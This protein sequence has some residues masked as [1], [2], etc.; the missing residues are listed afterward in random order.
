MT[1]KIQNLANIIIISP[2]IR[3]I[4]SILKMSVLEKL[5][6]L[7]FKLLKNSN[8]LALLLTKT[9]SNSLKTS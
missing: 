1:V 8:A 3:I 4:L 9:H 2:I 7:T 5:T 6:D